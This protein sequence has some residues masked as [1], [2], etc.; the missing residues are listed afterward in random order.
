MIVLGIESSCDETSV[1]VL[2]DGCV[3]SSRTHSQ[4]EHSLYGGVVPEVASRAHLEKIDILTK[5]VLDECGLAARSLDLIAV[6][7][8]PGLAG[9]LLVGVSFALGLHTAYGIPITGVNHLEGHIC[10]LFIEHK[11]IEA[12]FLVLLASGGHTAIY[13]Y[14]Q[15]GNCR[16]LGQTVDDAAGEAFDKVGKLLGFPYPAGRAI[17]EEASKVSGFKETEKITFP[18]ARFSSQ[19]TLDF[20]FSGLKTAVKNFILTNTGQYIKENRPQIC[21]AFQKAVATSLINNLWAASENCGIK[22]AA[23]AGGVACNGYLREELKTRF[24]AD[25]V[26]FPS[27]A[28]C[29]DNGAMIAMAGLKMYNSNRTRFPDMDP[30]RGINM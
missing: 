24:G 28:L 18:V 1:A 17:E 5:R 25:N 6:T 21:R 30:A 7:D 11:N 13:R 12:P 19:K 14:E 27:P 10:S 2:K 23:L 16:C 8:S 22:T 20:S 29:T 9:A 26:F 3:L 4:D 15:S